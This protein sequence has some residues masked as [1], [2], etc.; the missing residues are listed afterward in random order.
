VPQQR[1]ERGSP[2]RRATLESCKTRGVPGFGLDD[3]R[4][5][6][7]GVFSDAERHAIAKGVASAITDQFDR[8]E[9]ALA[10]SDLGAVADAAH[11]AR[12][13]TLLVGARALTTAFADLEQAARDGEQELAS[14]AAQQAKAIWPAT[15]AAIDEV[16]TGG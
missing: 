6:Q 7:L 16:A 13:E 9:R 15:H 2:P 3:D 10:T 1:G 5:A 12:N 8:L 4:L 11:R 14:A